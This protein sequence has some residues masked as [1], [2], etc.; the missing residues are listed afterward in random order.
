MDSKGSLPRSQQPDTGPVLSHCIPK[1]ISSKCYRASYY[2]MLC[3]V[4]LCYVML[5]YVML[6]YVMLCYVTKPCT[7]NVCDKIDKFDLSFV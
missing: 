7:I 6:C 4:M 1:I 3:Y 5:C 2:I